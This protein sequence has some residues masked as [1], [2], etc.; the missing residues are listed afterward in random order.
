M[1]FYVPSGNFR[2][3]HVLRPHSPHASCENTIV[4]FF[5][6]GLIDLF[7]PITRHN[8][9]LYNKWRPRPPSR[10]WALTTRSSTRARRTTA[11]RRRSRSSMVRDWERVG[12][13]SWLDSHTKPTRL[14]PPRPRTTPVHRK[15]ARRE[16]PGV[17]KRGR[18]GG[19]QGG[20]GGNARYVR[21]SMPLRGSD[22][23]C[24][25]SA[26]KPVPSLFL[27][28]SL[29]LSPRSH[30]GGEPGDAR[31]RG[32]NEGAGTAG[33]DGGDAGGGGAHPGGRVAGG[34]C[35]GERGGGQD[36]GGAHLPLG[37]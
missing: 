12:T 18:R 30:R 26:C 29:F 36:A 32:G 22:T 28:T 24:A 19:A 25:M 13:S 4:C 14:L 21:A 17:R 8:S 31:A 16:D 3:C 6:A 34:A 11:S 5:W 20:R 10:G 15:R 35:Q 1:D 27:L 9:Q 23:L 7:L 33:G 37:R 2:S